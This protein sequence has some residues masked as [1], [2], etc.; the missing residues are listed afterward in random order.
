MLSTFMG[1]RKFINGDKVSYVDFMLYE[2]LNC[3]LVFESWSLNAFENLKA[4]MQRIENL[5]PIKKYMS[6][7]CF[8]RLPVNAPFA[9]FGGQKE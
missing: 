3:N 8:A 7:G 4:F 6:S 2:I 5:K 9:T 1:D